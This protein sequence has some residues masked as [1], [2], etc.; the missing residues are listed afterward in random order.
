MQKI[1]NIPFHRPVIGSEELAAT[2]RVLE[3]GWI[4]TGN[5]CTL[6][7]RECAEAL[8]ARF[9]VSLSSATAGL[10]V[11]IKLG[12][13][14]QHS[15]IAV[16][17]LT[18]AAC[19]HV[20]IQA[21][22][23]PLFVDIAPDSFHMDPKLLEAHI[24]RYRNT[25]HPVSSIM[26]VHYAGEP[27]Y[28]DEYAGLATQYGLWLIEDAAHC[29]PL[30]N[31]EHSY[32][33]KDVAVFSFYATKPMTSAEG[34]LLCTNEEQPYIHAKILRSHGISQETWTRYKK[35]SS[36]Y[37]VVSD[38]YKYNLSDV[39]AAIARAQLLKQHTLLKARERIANEYTA[40]FTDG[41]GIIL[42]NPVHPVHAWHLFVIRIVS[43][44][45]S[46]DTLMK[47]LAKAGIQTSI[48]FRP[49]HHHSYFSHYVKDTLPYA[50][51]LADEILSLPIYPGLSH[52]DI[53]YI[54]D[55]TKKALAE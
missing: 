41:E 10:H 35:E 17:T 4:T 30:T 26:C 16:S 14:P 12:N 23:I 15:R 7:E 36:A 1:P 31:K 55:T 37:D 13:L 28:I 2:Q 54:V 33:K 18:F 39:H 29:A 43:K 9:A 22:H 34:G 19:G 40:L 27:R 38:G 6:L 3:S 8:K 46:R 44:N 25:D 51:K 21:G 45:I 48:H 49:L 24:I 47:T 50:D 52:K 5:E 32:P 53:E 42:P 11:A 20:I